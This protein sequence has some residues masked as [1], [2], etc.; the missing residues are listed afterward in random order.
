MFL[1]LIAVIVLICWG[2]GAL[3]GSGTS[4]L[5]GAL[6]GVVVSLVV[7]AVAGALAARNT[8]GDRPNGPPLQRW[9]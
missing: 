5:T 4:Y 3:V 2:L 6:I 8:P 9:D 7:L 1:W